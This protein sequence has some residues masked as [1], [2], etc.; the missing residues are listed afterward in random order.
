MKVMVTQSDPL[1]AGVGLTVVGLHE[2][3]ALPAA[4]AELAGA[5]DAKG[6]FKKKLLLHSG[7]ARALVVGLGKREEADAERLRVAAALAAKEAARL[8]LD[9]IAWAL[10][11]SADENAAAEALVTGTILGSYRYD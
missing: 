11:E 10:P 1:E 4:I 6:A 3:G 8:E 7:T 5:G 2:D 9:S